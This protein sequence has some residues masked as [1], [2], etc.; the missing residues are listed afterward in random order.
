MRIAAGSVILLPFIVAALWPVTFDSRE[1]L[2]EIPKGTWARRQAGD[3]TEILPSQIRLLVGVRDVLVLKNS[4]DVPQIFGPTLLMPG[5]TFRLPFSTPSENYFSCTAHASGQL[6]I[7]VEAA[8]KWP[9]SRLAWRTRQM[10][11]KVSLLAAAAAADVK[12]KAGVFDPPRRAPEMALQ[13]T[14]GQPLG[15]N[16]YRGKVVLLAFGYSSCPS[17]CPTTLA[18]FAKARRQLGEAAQRVQVVYVTVDPER[19]GRD[20]LGKFVTG[21]DP[22]FVGGTGSPAQI[23]AVLQNY[24]VSARKIPLEGGYGYSHSSFTYLS[25]RNG[26]IRALMPYGHGADDF[27]NDLKILLAS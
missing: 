15:L 8:P 25:D 6:L 10:W 17:I 3:K 19:D 13:G 5:Q 9:W 14:D 18:T 24:G 21:F 12:L 11:R 1:E 2:F 26:M 4:D 23:A 16:R 20:R 7:T 27:V 22:T